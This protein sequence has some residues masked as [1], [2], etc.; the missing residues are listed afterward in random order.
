MSETDACACY[1]IN[2]TVDGEH[3]VLAH[4]P[5]SR[6]AT[7]AAQY[8]VYIT[9]YLDGA[10]D[11]IVLGNPVL[12]RVID[13]SNDE[14]YSTEANEEGFITI[15]TVDVSLAPMEIKTI[16]V[17]LSPARN[18]ESINPSALLISDAVMVKETE[19][20]R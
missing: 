7:T 17:K 12:T 6:Q 20:A 15:G 18:Q 14:A 8:D 2:T 19:R 1:A 5:V 3:D 10:C 13:Q 9:D 4:F 11:E 16:V